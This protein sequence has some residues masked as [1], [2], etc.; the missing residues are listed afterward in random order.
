MTDRLADESEHNSAEPEAHIKSAH[1][2]LKGAQK[3]IG[4]RALVADHM[5]PKKAAPSGNNK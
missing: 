3:K 2:L 4:E 1:K 5:S